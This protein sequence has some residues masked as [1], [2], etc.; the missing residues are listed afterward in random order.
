MSIPRPARTERST[1]TPVAPWNGLTIAPLPVGLTPLIG[2]Q[3]EIET[4]QD[5]FHREAVRLIT[6]T[7][8]GGIG[9][10]RLAIDLAHHLQTELRCQVVF[11]PL[12]A[13]R[14]PQDVV[15]AILL[16]VG[17]SDQGLIDPP[18]SLASALVHAEMLIV[19]DNFEQVLGARGNLA[20]LLAAAPRLRLLVTSR[21]RLRLRGE[22]VV[23]VPPLGLSDPAGMGPVDPEAL[24]S[25]AVRLF[26]ERS[27]AV[28]SGL[29]VSGADAALA[30]SICRRLDGLPLAIELAAA[31]VTHLSLAMLDQRLGRSLP[32]LVAG[33]EDLPERQRTLRDTIAWSYDLLTGSQQRVF[34]QVAVFRGGFTLEA[35]ETVMGGTGETSPSGRRATDGLLSGTGTATDDLAVLNVLQTLVEASLVIHAT[36]ADGESRYSTLETISE[37]AG[38]ALAA[39]GEL[40]S[41]RQRH[42]DWYLVFAES[43]EVRP[44]SPEATERSRQLA[45]EQPNMVAA[46]E[47]LESIGDRAGLGRLVAA[48]GWSWWLRGEWRSGQPWLGR[49]WDDVE[50]RG[51]LAPTALTSVGVALGLISAAG[52]DDVPRSKEILE[53]CLGLVRPQGDVLG[54]VSASIGLGWVTG[55]IGDQDAGTRYLNEALRLARE[56]PASRMASSVTGV[57][58][59]NLGAVH[60]WAGRYEDAAMVLDEGRAVLSEA[61]NATAMLF[62]LID[63]GYLARD[64]GRYTVAASLFAQVLGPARGIGDR[65]YLL[66]V[67]EGMATVAVATGDHALGVR[68]LAV[69][70]REYRTFGMTGHTPTDRARREAATAAARTAMGDEAYGKAENEGVQ[71]S[72]DQAIA[73]ASDPKSIVVDV[74]P[75]EPGLLTR[76]ETEILRLLAGG[77]TNREIAECLFIGERT[78]ESHLER[79]YAKL[80]VRRRLAAI[81]AA[82]RLGLLG[83]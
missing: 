38:E 7:G 30:A 35:A 47:W 5:L 3:R 10:T 57:I 58:L 75:P 65:R 37:F 15:P 51:S 11:V 83:P 34:R 50:I 43:K 59:N 82:T 64:M 39:A 46:I 63:R 68:L 21:S 55:M 2:R 45:A 44:F 53:V 40:D 17:L 70:E 61:N 56:L 12:E 71:L 6:L 41:A 8:P 25:D 20:A 79:I 42:A 9:K 62:N 18:A 80:G 26:V 32:M 14:R 54:I 24:D 4:V 33:A 77:R 78:I 23:P 36:G 49:V 76:R 52:S 31:R 19:I 67:L 13:I 22:H 69:V 60:R 27:A 81:A 29:R 72:I 48:L 28:V 73:L 74:P 16:A 66:G 1:R